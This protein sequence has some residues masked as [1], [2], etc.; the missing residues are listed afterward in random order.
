M[1]S[2][3]TVHQFVP[4]V[5]LV[6]VNVLHTVASTG[7][8]DYTESECLS[9]AT[10]CRWFSYRPTCELCESWLNVT[11]VTGC[12]EWTPL[13]Y[14]QRMF[15]EAQR[16]WGKDPAQDEFKKA[17]RHFQ[18][19]QGN[20]EPGNPHRKSWKCSVW[21][22]ES[23]PFNCEGQ[24]RAS[25]E[26]KGVNYG[27]RFVP[28]RYLGLP[29]TFN[30]FD[31]VE[32]PENI[33]GRPVGSVSLCDVG[34]QV[35]EAA[36]RVS[37]FLDLNIKEE[38]F[39][40]MAGLGFNVVR[41]PLGY[42]NLIDLPGNSTPNGLTP[43]RWFALQ[44]IM[45]AEGYLKWIDRV[46]AYAERA[47]MRVLLDFHGAPGAQTG[48]AFTGC[49]QGKGNYHFDTPWNKKLAVRS[50]DKMAQLCQ[51]HSKSCYGIELLNEPAFGNDESLRQF[52]K[53]YYHEAIQAAR[54]HLHPDV[55]L[56][57]MDWTKWLPWWKNQNVFNYRDHGRVVFSTHLYDGFGVEHQSVVRQAFQADLSAVEDFYCNSKHEV[58]VSEY[59][60]SGHG[61]GNPGVDP[62]DYHSLANWLVPQISQRSLGSAVWNYDAAIF[63]RI[64]GPVAHDNLGVRPVNWA[65]I[66]DVPPLPLKP[67]G[68]NRTK[69]DKRDYHLRGSDGFLEQLQDA[70]G[71]GQGQPGS[72]RRGTSALALVAFFSL[73][74]SLALH[75]RQRSGSSKCREVQ[76]EI[77]DCG[78]SCSSA[79]ELSSLSSSMSSKAEEEKTS[80]EVSYSPLLLG[81]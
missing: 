29:G 61:N 4:A 3:H 60:L 74:A 63:S 39:E 12:R 62:F 40:R 59:S 69:E 72:S 47:G 77:G 15:Q 13:E 2:C 20:G 21:C 58:I 34:Q 54:Q 19:S 78:D 8:A 45:P 17:L 49:D 75:L 11:T 44:S 7:C 57:V 27:G 46:F 42:W 67:L 55:P 50:V 76:A 48:N 22:D 33:L 31:G 53:E 38:H 18:V 9:H 35:P 5:L 24:P 28:E 68:T 10:S 16:E 14:C 80:S 23:V 65:K 70:V 6:G 51:A 41:V 71:G 43:D 52:L 66:F 1:G 64:W 79:T 81:A 56:V 32:H 26:M 30:L 25:D 37:T 36:E 73:V